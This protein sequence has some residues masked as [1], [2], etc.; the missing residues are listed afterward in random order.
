MRKINLKNCTKTVRKMTSK[1]FLMVIILCSF[2][3]S[4]S[5]AQTDSLRQGIARITATKNADVGMAIYGFESKDTL[6]LN[7]NKH[8]P[9]QSVFKFHI[10]LAVLNEV[11]KGKL[12]LNQEIK[13]NQGDLLPNTWSPLREKYPKGNIKL[14]LSE[15]LS[16]TVSQSDNNVCDILLKLIGGTKTVQNFMDSIG[17]KD[18][19]I[20]ANEEEAHKDWNV[21]FSNWT[22]PISSIQVLRKFYDRKILS[23]KSS[24]Y[25]WTLLTETS[26]GRNRIKGQLPA[27]TSVAHKTG[28]SFTSKQGITAAVNDIGIVSLPNGE[29]FAISIFVTNSKESETANEKIIAD[30][31]ELAWKYFTNKMQKQ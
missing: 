8:F 17:I 1:T 15:M 16:Y 27:G 18:F 14:T 22:T 30:I 6:S 2:N 31:A 26:T 9:M 11:D 5:T 25:L 3:I 29:H 7:G 4:S 19:S 12:S 23:Q 10:A 28:T 24:D 13:I 21:Q 20:H